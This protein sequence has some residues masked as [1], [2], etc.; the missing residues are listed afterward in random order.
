MIISNAISDC[1]G[2][3]DGVTYVRIC[4]RDCCFSV[5]AVEVKIPEFVGWRAHTSDDCVSLIVDGDNV[6]GEAGSAS[7]VA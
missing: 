5:V 3:V 4:C 6:G 2:W 1:C 7:M